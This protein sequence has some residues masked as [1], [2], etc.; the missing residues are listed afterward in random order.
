MWQFGAD[1]YAFYQTHSDHQ[2]W[3]HTYEGSTP[4]CGTG[5]QWHK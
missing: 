1:L 3:A 2:K 4:E 5:T